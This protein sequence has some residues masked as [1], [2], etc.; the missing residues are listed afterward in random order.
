VWS[1]GGAILKTRDLVLGLAV[2]GSI[3]AISV[4]LTARGAPSAPSFVQIDAGYAHTC[5]ITSRGGVKC[6]GA[7]SHGQLGNDTRRL[8]RVPVDVIGLE[9]GVKAISAGGSHTCA[10][11]ST[12]RAKCWGRN[13]TGQL[14]NG[15][16]KSSRTPVDVVGLASGIKAIATGDFHSCALTS[17]GGM[18]CWGANNEGQL[19]N[20]SRTERHT[21]VDV[22]GLQSG[23]STIAAGVQRSCAVTSAGAAMCLGLS[24]PAPA[25]GLEN[26]VKEISIGWSSVSPGVGT[27][28]LICALMRS[29]AVKCL[30]GGPLPTDVSGL[31]S[32]VR[33]LD[34]G[35]LFNCAVTSGGWAKCWG[36]N[37]SGQ[38]GIGSRTDRPVPADVI[39][40]G[41]GV[42][43]IT[44][45]GQHSCA[46]TSRGK[47]KCWGKNSSGELGNGVK[48]Y[49]V[50]TKPVNVVAAPSGSSGGQ[51]GPS[52]TYRL[53]WPPRPVQTATYNL[54]FNS[55]RP[56][57]I[58]LR[59]YGITVPRGLGISFLVA[60][61]HRGPAALSWDW[62]QRGSAVRVTV[63]MTTG[64]CFRP[65]QQVAGTY[66]SVNFR[67]MR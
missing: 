35:E 6:W 34:T 48:S 59:V 4:P 33:A 22:I 58:S 5:A 49:G 2:A 15:S 9:R 23:V 24:R 55:V 51:S 36:Q 43:A 54:T 57:A 21:P 20:G 18:K 32:G 66:A 47:I 3:L 63:K 62:K 10:V 8:S 11:T 26:G 45:G 67:L 44:T 29:G 64:H 12:G 61:E 60:C 37:R 30:R 16:T 7:N 13:L 46:L 1:G 14:G 40:L 52:R 65:G 42:T 41:R 17:R 39:G 50:S 19:G 31:G 25:R 28:V 27:G 53:R 56:R 38:L